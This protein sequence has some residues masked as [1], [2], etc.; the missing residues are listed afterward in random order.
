MTAMLNRDELFAACRT[1][2]NMAEGHFILPPLLRDV[3]TLEI[4]DD[5]CYTLTAG[6]RLRFL[7]KFDKSYAKCADFPLDRLPLRFEIQF[8]DQESK[9]TPCL[10]DADRKALI[11]AFLLGAKVPIIAKK[12]RIAEVYKM[13]LQVSET[14]FLECGELKDEGAD[15]TLQSVCDHV[16]RALI[17]KS[18][19]FFANQEDG[20]EVWR[21]RVSQELFGD[22]RPPAEFFWPHRR[23]YSSNHILCE[24][25]SEIFL[26]ATAP[27][28]LA[29]PAQAPSD[30]GDSCESIPTI[31]ITANRLPTV[32]TVKSRSS[33][34]RYVA[35]NV[36]AVAG[37]ALASAQPC[38][39]D[40][41]PFSG[42]GITSGSP[43]P[44]AS[45]VPSSNPN[46]AAVVSAVQKVVA[47][48]PVASEDAKLRPESPQSQKVV[49]G[50]YP[51]NH[52][53]SRAVQLAKLTSPTPLAEAA[54]SQE[55]A[56]PRWLQAEPRRGKTVQNLLK[57]KSTTIKTAV[58]HRA[59]PIVVVG[60]TMNA[61]AFGIASN[62][63]RITYR[64]SSVMS[65]R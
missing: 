54:P 37:I 30:A 34:A 18:E 41:L 13:L 22:P 27:T 28:V 9:D 51:S 11:R 31:A 50:E 16:S 47:V 23:Q 17:A 12:S 64:L 5:K 36:L 58:S 44:L 56:Q 53:T 25:T 43:R 21:A 57:I 48:A 63:R 2:Y 55:H 65:E 60:R 10:G 49:I 33:R 8:C 61:L 32:S 40:F 20:L 24:L 46:K 26:P 59:S 3:E 39:I 19:T 42:G 14:F 29:R 52:G 15:L 6:R 62:V 7:V 35:T 38:L 45:T 4:R 1:L